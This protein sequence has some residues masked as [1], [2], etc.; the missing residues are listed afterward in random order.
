MSVSINSNIEWKLLLNSPLTEAE[1]TESINSVQEIIINPNDK[2]QFK[3]WKREIINENDKVVP[4]ILSLKLNNVYKIKTLSILTNSKFI[5][6]YLPIENDN[7]EAGKKYLVTCKSTTINQTRFGFLIHENLNLDEGYSE[8]DLHFLSIKGE[9][10]LL[11]ILQFELETE[12]ISQKPEKKPN[13]I[14]SNPTTPIDPSL[15]F[16]MM[17]MFKS[18]QLTA[19]S[20]SLSQISNQLNIKNNQNLSIP[21]FTNTSL[22]NIESKLN[23]PPPNSNVTLSSTIQL[24]I[25]I[26]AND[27]IKLLEHP[28]VSQYLNYIIDKKVELKMKQLEE[29]LIEKFSNFNLTNETNNNNVSDN[30]NQNI[31]QE[32][33]LEVNNI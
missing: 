22:S 3:A 30:S 21:N 9:P 15:L 33:S 29:R 27:M 25:S 16:G 26:S 4:F 7:K 10:N 18:P 13:P 11:H 31:S 1:D 23:S 24:P 19:T 8:L 2:F 14:V 5:E 20:N 12:F 28:Q 32:N 17:G 6:L